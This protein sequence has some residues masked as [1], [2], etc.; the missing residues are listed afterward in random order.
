[1]LHHYYFSFRER[2]GS[3]IEGRGRWRRRQQHAMRNRIDTVLYTRMDS[4]P[5][6]STGKINTR[7]VVSLR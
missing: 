1:M 4:E 5:H 6:G 3:G 2:F 7:V